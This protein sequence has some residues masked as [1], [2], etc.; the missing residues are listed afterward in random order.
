MCGVG[1]LDGVCLCEWE[2]VAHLNWIS[3]RMEVA[4]LCG[5]VRVVGDLA[6]CEVAYRVSRREV[7]V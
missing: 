1:V 6:V 2:S 4:M 3:E 5:G 7:D